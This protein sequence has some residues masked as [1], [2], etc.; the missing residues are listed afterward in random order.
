MNEK[1]LQT[2]RQVVCDLHWMARRYADGRM[3][4]VTDLFNSHTRALL[5]ELGFSYED[6]EGTDGTIWAR[7]K[8]GRD[9]D[10]L[11]DEEANLGEET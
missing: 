7:D 11:S 3:S 6:L 2:L 5:E 10:G 4:Y 1:D 8:M 9:Y